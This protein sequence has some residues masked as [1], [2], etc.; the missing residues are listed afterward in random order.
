MPIIC[1]VS[2]L[3]MTELRSEE[4]SQSNS[5]TEMTRVLEKGKG[6]L[7]D[8]RTRKSSISSNRYL[9]SGEGGLLMG[10]TFRNSE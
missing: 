10:S 6:L 4:S 5:E 7:G 8:D 2:H 3:V 9:P 1:Q